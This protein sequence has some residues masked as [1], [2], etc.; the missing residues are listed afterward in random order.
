M[1]PAGW[2]CDTEPR[3]AGSEMTTRQKAPATGAATKPFIRDCHRRTRPPSVFACSKGRCPT[4]S[5]GK[6]LPPRGP[7]SPTHCITCGPASPDRDAPAA[8]KR[9][10]AA[11]RRS[12]R[13]HCEATPMNDPA[14]I[15]QGR[16]RCRRTKQ[17]PPWCFPMPCH[18]LGCCHGGNCPRS[19]AVARGLRLIAL[20]PHSPV[21]AVVG[22]QTLGDQMVACAAAPGD[23]GCGQNL[24][25]VALFQGCLSNASSQMFRHAVCDA[26]L[27]IDDHFQRFPCCDLVH[28]S[29]KNDDND[30]RAFA[31]ADHYGRLQCRHALPRIL[32]GAAQEPE[33]AQPG[34]R[35]LRNEPAGQPSTPSRS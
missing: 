24:P 3:F 6:M 14:F 21:P 20:S 13:R 26:R 31:G 4:T 29:T 10:P 9:A 2:A 19:V 22:G 17:W 28:T 33:N 1:P 35:Q 16:I 23:Q 30:A 11:C 18:F 12:A 7:Q 5:T 15:S 27:A 8:A 25:S 34:L 32:R